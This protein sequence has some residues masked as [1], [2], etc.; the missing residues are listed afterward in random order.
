[1][2]KR[3][4]TP[5]NFL[6]GYL[7]LFFGAKKTILIGGALLGEA[8]RTLQTVVARR[9]AEG[10]IHNTTGS[11]TLSSQARCL[12]VSGRD[13]L[14]EKQKY[15]KAAVPA[16]MSLKEI[17]KPLGQ[18]PPI[19]AQTTAPTPQPVGGVHTMQ[20]RSE[21]RRRSHLRGIHAR[22]AGAAPVFDVGGVWGDEWGS[23]KRKDDNLGGYTALCW[24]ALPAGRSS[25]RRRAGR[26]RR[27]WRRGWPCCS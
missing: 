20:R 5:T 2:A 16:G 4:Y 23:R 21:D 6:H 18:S 7:S 24:V 9:C 3:L 27:W 19:H 12:L 17:V 26:R 11:N 1:V 13:L 14:R 8:A 22:T 25:R 10:H 15:H